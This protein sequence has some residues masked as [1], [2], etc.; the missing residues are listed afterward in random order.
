MTTIADVDAFLRPRAPATQGPASR[1]CTCV[2]SC[3]GAAGLAP[4]WVCVIERDRAERAA[5]TTGPATCGA[6]GYTMALCACVCCEH[7]KPSR[8]VCPDCAPLYVNEQ[9]EIIP[10]PGFPYVEPAVP[11]ETAEYHAQGDPPADVLAI[12]RA[13]YHQ[14]TGTACRCPANGPCPCACHRGPIETGRPVCGH[15][16]GMKRVTFGPRGQTIPA[17]EVESRSQPCPACAAPETSVA[18]S[19]PT[20]P[21]PLRMQPGQR[22]TKR[23]HG[24][25]EA[26]FWDRQ[27]AEA[28]LMSEEKR[29]RLLPAEPAAQTPHRCLYIEA[30]ADHLA[31]SAA[32]A[33]AAV[34]PFREP[35]PAPQG[36]PTTQDKR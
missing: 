32:N 21:E 31:T 1:E 7:G 36:T 5:A 8:K 2:G 35:S 12:V 20:P 3:K 4:G 25:E 30:P 22:C 11:T 16:L 33:K 19:Q 13:E 23:E 28:W 14:R 26:H 9:W 29:L 27:Q 34:A 15:C 18:E 17:T 6:C 10:P 24:A